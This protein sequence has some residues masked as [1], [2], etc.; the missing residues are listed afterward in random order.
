M[1]WEKWL[2]VAFFSFEALA[3]IGRIGRPRK[4]ITNQEAIL[5]VVLWVCWAVLV[6]R[7]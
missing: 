2:L 5:A 7:A 3:V 4:P 1:S 6:V